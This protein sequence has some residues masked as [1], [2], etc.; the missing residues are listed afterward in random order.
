M[1]LYSGSVGGLLCWNSVVAHLTEGLILAAAL[2]L[3]IRPATTLL[4]MLGSR[5]AG[6]ARM[7]AGWFDIRGIGSLYYLSFAVVAGLPAV[8]TERLTWMVFIVVA[9]SVIA[10]G[11]TA[12]PLMSRYQRIAR[13]GA[14]NK[15]VVTAFAR[16]KEG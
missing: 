4:A 14:R 9:L 11:V 5:M 12:T 7:L 8:L 10:H 16:T 6:R 3:V 15:A 13:Q 2:L 1:P